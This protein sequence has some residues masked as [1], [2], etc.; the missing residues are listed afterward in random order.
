M[1]LGKGSAARQST[2][3]T[4]SAAEPK[5]HK[6]DGGVLPTKRDVTTLQMYLDIFIAPSRLRASS[7]PENDV[8]QP[9]RLNG[10]TLMT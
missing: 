1:L 7:V 2:E 4:K 10:K 3:S 8:S 9:I 6:C 5:S